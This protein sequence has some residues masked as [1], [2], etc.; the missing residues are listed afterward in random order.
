MQTRF[1][2]ST[3]TYAHCRALACAT[4]RIF[5]GHVIENE[6]PSLFAKV[7]PDSK[8]AFLDAEECAR[9]QTHEQTIY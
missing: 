1:R 2:S 5:I 3:F 6:E 8:Q 4:P 9:L 7:N